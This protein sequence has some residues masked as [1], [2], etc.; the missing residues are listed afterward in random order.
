[1]SAPVIVSGV[2]PALTVEQQLCSALLD[3]IEAA[4][5]MLGTC[6]CIRGDTPEDADTHT[7]DDWAEK[8]LR[9]RVQEVRAAVDK[10]LPK[11]QRGANW[12]FPSS[13]PAVRDA[14]A[15]EHQAQQRD[16]VVNGE[17]GLL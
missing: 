15:R 10:A 5:A 16:A 11:P 12:P 8:F 17:R 6:G 4:E 13:D 1:M 3:L 7:H 9:E 2:R 14:M